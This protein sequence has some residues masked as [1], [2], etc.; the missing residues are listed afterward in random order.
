MG[1]VE[2]SGRGKTGPFV[3][4]LIGWLVLG[5]SSHAAKTSAWIKRQE[6]NGLCI[7]C[8]DSW[9]QTQLLSSLK[10]NKSKHEH[11]HTGQN[12]ENGGVTLSRQKYGKRTYRQRNSSKRAR[13]GATRD[14]PGSL[15]KG[16]DCKVLPRTARIVSGDRRT[17]ITRR[18]GETRNPKMR[19]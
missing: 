8:H 7:R 13:R 17:P 2:L 3:C 19:Q 12:T 9:A 18:G 1:R 16:A 5:G 6:I 11:Q 14:I 4:W 15:Q 10:T